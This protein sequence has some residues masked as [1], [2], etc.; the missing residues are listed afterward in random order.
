MSFWFDYQLEYGCVV[1]TKT[2]TIKGKTFLFKEGN[3]NCFLG[4]PFA[5]NGIYQNRFQVSLNFNNFNS[6]FHLLKLYII[7]F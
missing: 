6:N 2:G 1:Q 5:K 4:V 7:N 3:V